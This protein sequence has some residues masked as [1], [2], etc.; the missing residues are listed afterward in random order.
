MADCRGSC[1]LRP[2]YET[3]MM[4]DVALRTKPDSR[5][6]SPQP[7]MLVSVTRQFRVVSMGLAPVVPARRE[8]RS[9]VLHERVGAVAAAFVQLRACGVPA[10]VL[11]RPATRRHID[12][13][14]TPRTFRGKQSERVDFFWHPVDFFFQS[15]SSGIKSKAQK[16]EDLFAEAPVGAGWGPR[17]TLAYRGPSDRL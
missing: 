9:R 4:I 8:T 13:G 15:T 10:A 5:A 16:S 14:C 6:L 7:R 17:R 12:T 1:N 3:H 2:C 11:V